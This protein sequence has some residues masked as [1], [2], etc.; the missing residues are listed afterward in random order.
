[1]AIAGLI[2]PFSGPERQVD[3]VLAAL[4]E[5]GVRELKEGRQDIGIGDA[6]SRQVAVG[7]ELGRDE[8]VRSHEGPDPLEQVA[9]AIV[10]ALRH[11]GAMQAEHDAV[12]R[13]GGPQL[14]KDLVAQLLIGLALHEA[15]RLGPGSSAFDDV[16]RLGPGAAP[17]GHDWR[18]A[19]GRG[20]GM[21]A[22]GRIERSLEARAIGRD[23]RER[24]G[25]GG[26]RCREDAH[27]RGSDRQLAAAW[28]SCRASSRNSSRQR[29]RCGASAS[30]GRTKH[31]VKSVTLSRPTIGTA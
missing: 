25:F 12:D 7:I 9:L 3:H 5:V 8:D 29:S 6:L 16:D 22:R 26:Q 13:Q 2:S 31:S 4:V 27:G 21:G 20:L 24:V 19:Q 14:P 15:A 1:M 10:I 23:R 30:L 17:Q 18:R 28:L 11:H